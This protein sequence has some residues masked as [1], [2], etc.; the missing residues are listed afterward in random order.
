MAGVSLP[1]PP[2]LECGGFGVFM[3]SAA[4]SNTDQDA[5]ELVGSG[6]SFEAR[7][8]LRIRVLALFL[9][10][11]LVAGSTRGVML[12]GTGDPNANT[13]A[14]TGA[15]TNSGWQ[16]EGQFGVFLGTAIAANYFITA[17]HIGGNVG[18][19]FVLNNVSYTTIA[20]FPDLST[21]LQ[22]WQISGTFPAYAPI[23]SGAAGS[24]V[25]L[26]LVVFGRGT[27][28]GNPVTVG[29][30]SHL[31]GW[32]WG[33]LD[34]I[35]RWGT[36]VVGSIQADP[37]Y[38]QLLRVPFDSNGGQNEAHLSV[39]DSGGAVFVFNG[40]T[41]QWELAGINLAVD[42]PFSTSAAGTNAF[43]AAMFDTTG[44]FVEGGQGNWVTAP[45]P[46]AFYA[47]EIAPREGFINSVVMQLT[48]V[49]SQKTH[50][51]AGT[52]NIELPQTAKPGIECRS[53]GPTEDYTI[54]FTFAHDIS[55]SD[56][57]VTSGVGS[58]VNF[59]VTSNQVTVNLT[60]VD[61]QQII[62]ITLFNVSDG[63]NTRNVQATMG[64]LLGD[65]N[66]DSQ[67]DSGD[68]LLVKQQTLQPV[69]DNAG[70]SNFREDVNT[71]G[72]I[73]SG[74]LIITKRQT[75]TGLP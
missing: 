13:T 53:G 6:P 74:D 9:S 65:V 25:N 75:L 33:P 34:G 36:N 24:E 48:S 60:G 68:L 32:L 41:N 39:G 64:V 66:A 27:Q 14:P 73:D 3:N 10:L 38:G 4:N 29:N 8:G 51:S 7:S 21:D 37:T 47:T 70:T 22:V 1:Y 2:L 62:V 28:R 52:F 59:S 67:V 35:E 72:N 49:V 55:V 20:V 44:L 45:N 11:L 12:Y 40:D 31:G 15:L 19:I 71:D 63:I 56:A 23:Y 61:N 17:R 46:S 18:D 50:G 16:Y 5:H 54:L 42:G 43:D 58:V 69:N 57:E 30:D 26:S